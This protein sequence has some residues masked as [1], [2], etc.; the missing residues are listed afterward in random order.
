MDLNGVKELAQLARSRT[1]SAMERH[2]AV[3][4]EIQSEY[5]AA[6]EKMDHARSPEDLQEAWRMMDAA[7]VRETEHHDKVAAWLTQSH[8][9][10]VG[11]FLRACD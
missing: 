11:G 2:H 3:L 10:I 5:V 1:D 4:R 8:E 9:M 7:V 6:W